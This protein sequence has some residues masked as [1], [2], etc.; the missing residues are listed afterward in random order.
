MSPSYR[1]CLLPPR[2]YREG[3]N[4]PGVIGVAGKNNPLYAMHPRTAVLMYVVFATD[5]LVEALDNNTRIQNCSVE[6]HRA[7]SEAN[8][9]LQEPAATR[10]HEPLVELTNRVMDMGAK[11]SSPSQQGVAKAS[12]SSCERPQDGAGQAC[13]PKWIPKREKMEP[14]HQLTSRLVMCIFLQ[15]VA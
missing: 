15:G 12:P 8:A 2:F 3:E 11:S 13:P 1:V 6:L 4:R 5:A 7:L 10:V 9:F 14:P